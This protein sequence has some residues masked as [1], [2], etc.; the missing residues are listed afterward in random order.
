MLAVLLQDPFEDAEKL[1]SHGARLAFGGPI[2]PRGRV[3]ECFG[4]EGRGVEIVGV[5]QGDSAHRVGVGFVELGAIFS[6]LA[7][8]SLRQGLNVGSLSFTYGGGEPESTVE[9][10]P[11]IGMCR[12]VHHRVDVGTEYE[13]ETP[14]THRAARVDLGG[15]TKG[16]GGFFVVEAVRKR[17][18][19]V[20][21]E[22][23]F[24]GLG[25]DL[26]MMSAHALD[27]MTMAVVCEA[28]RSGGEQDQEEQSFDA[29]HGCLR[30]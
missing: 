4:K 30:R 6:R 5:T 15:V 8:I 11:R 24:G 7:S 1:D 17:E 28:C 21:E 29:S 27:Q 9:G 22:L 14:E 18:P 20:E 25:R 19:L 3:H 26:V 2:V 10:L 16:F 12:G 13:A 23:S